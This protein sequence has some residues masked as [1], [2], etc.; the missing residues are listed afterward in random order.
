VSRDYI[1]I[2]KPGIIFG[3]LI[4]TA[5]GFFLASRG[6]VDI[7]VLLATLTG[8]SLVVASG[9]VLNNWIDRNLDRMMKRT[10]NRVFARGALSART[11]CLY[12]SLLGITGIALLGTAANM[13]CVAIVLA[14]FGIYVGIYSLHL[15]RTSVHATW[16]GSLAGAAP[17]LAGYCAVANRFDVG[18]VIL[19]AIFILWQIPHYYAIAVFRFDDYA[20]AAIPILPVKQGTTAAKKHIVGYI[21]VF[22]AA[23]LMLTFCGYTGYSYFAVTAVSGLVWLFIAWSGF[24]TSDERLWARRVYIFS[25]LAMCVMS[26]MMSIDFTLAG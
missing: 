2:A 16:I 17:P 1:D 21:L 23:T 22:I 20:A 14:G 18:A 7:A 24:K 12:A 13:L 10:R 15:K 8:V 26:F 11:A 19:L 25:I 6:R 5:G 3:N 4:S 9:C